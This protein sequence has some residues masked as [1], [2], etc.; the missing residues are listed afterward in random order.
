MLEAAGGRIS[1]RSIGCK[2]MMERQ[3]GE[4]TGSSSS[5]VSEIDSH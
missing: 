1:Q 4:E 2:R 5:A 3:K